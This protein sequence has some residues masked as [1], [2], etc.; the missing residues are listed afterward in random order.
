MI[1]AEAAAPLGVSGTHSS[2]PPPAA[3][4]GSTSLALAST[5]ESMSADNVRGS[6]ACAADK[7]E[8]GRHEPASL[9][10]R[11]QL[12]LRGFRRFIASAK[13]GMARSGV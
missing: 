13:S 10:Q 8:K 11:G 12:R 2:Q 7:T 1:A 5:E 9:L 3:S 6:S 4:S